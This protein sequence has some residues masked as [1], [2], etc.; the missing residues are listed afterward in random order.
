MRENQSSV[1]LI[2]ELPDS[3]DAA[4]ETLE[5]DE[6]SDEEIEYD[7]KEGFEDSVGKSSEAFDENDNTI[8]DYDDFESGGSTEVVGFSSSYGPSDINI[9]YENQ[10]EVVFESSGGGSW[11]VKTADGQPETIPNYE[12]VLVLVRKLLK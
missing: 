4:I 10:K 8:E 11:T 5:K 1:T 9:T 2:W 7:D 3:A 6:W 12:A